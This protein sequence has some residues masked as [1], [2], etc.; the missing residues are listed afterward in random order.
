MNPTEDEAGRPQRSDVAE[1]AARL[2]ESVGGPLLHV[3]TDRFRLSQE[4]AKALLSLVCLR[5]MTQDVKNREAWAVVSACHGAQTLRRR[6]DQGTAAPPPDITVEELE[7]LREVVLVGKALATIT[8][9]GREALRLRFHEQRSYAEI[10]AE[11]DVTEKYAKH[12]VFRSL[13]RLRASQGDGIANARA[14]DVEQER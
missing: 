13:Q 7:A 10:A 11:L 5:A 2:Y 6:H 1:A 9:H 3:L 8:R 14:E 4:E 12:L